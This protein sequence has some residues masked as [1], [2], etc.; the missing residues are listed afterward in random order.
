MRK[1]FTKVNSTIFWV[2]VLTVNLLAQTGCA[3]HAHSSKAGSP[4]VLDHMAVPLSFN[5][6][7]EPILSE[8]CYSCHGP[9]P[10]ARKAGLRID[11]AQFAFV[12]RADG[13]P[14]IVKGDP[15]HS[16]LILRIESKDTK[17]MMPPP[18]A[19]RILKADQVAILRRWVKEGAKY[20]EHWS[21]IPPHRPAV[22][23]TVRTDWPRSPIDK[24]VLAR[25]EREGLAPSPEADSYALIR[26]VT[27]DLIGL[28]PTPEEVDAFVQDRSPGAYE[29][30]V[31]RLLASPGFGEHRAHYWLDLARYGDTHGLHLDNYRSVWPYRDYVIRSF[32]TNKPFDQFACEQLA[33]DL[34]PPKNVDQ[35]VATAF[36][37]AGISSG[38]GGTIPEEL[39]V[40]NQRERTEAF[41]AVFLGLTVGC[42]VCHDHKFDPITQKDFYQLS[43]FWNNLEEFPS[44]KNRDNWPPFI[45]VPKKENQ[46][47]FNATL[48][49][50]ARI[51]EQLN[52]RRKDGRKLLTDWLRQ[53]LHLA[54]PVPS[55]GLKV[56]LRFDEQIGAIA[57]NSAPG[58][59]P[60]KIAATGGAPIWGEETWF[61]PSFRMDTTTRVEL[62]N[63]G[64]VEENQP[65]SIG[66]WLKPYLGTD[67]S[68]VHPFGA[69]VSRNQGTRGWELYFDHDKVSFRLVHSWPHNLIS[70][71]T[72]K[73]VLAR[74]RWNHVLATYDGTC[75]AS[76]IRLYIDGKPQELRVVQDAL[77]GSIHTTSPMELGREFPDSNPL[78]QSI[79]QDLRFYSRAL[80]PDE[81]RRVPYEDY[82][83][84]ITRRPLDDWS[85]D[86]FKTVSD[87]YFSNRD[88]PSRILAAKIPALET[89]LNRL[90]KDGDTCL[91]CQET[92]R[93][94]YANVLDRGVYTQRK[95]RVRPAVPHFLPQP[96]SGAPLDRKTLADWV[97]S[98]INPLTARV[99]VNRMWQELFGDGLVATPENF[100]LMGDR[101]SQPELLD[102]LAV[103]FRESGWNIKRFYKQVVMSATYRQSARVTP[104]ALER[105]PRN[106]LLARGPRFRMDAEMIRDTALAASGLLVSKIGGP[107]V[108]PYQPQ[109]TWESGT[110]D[111]SNTYR[112]VPG[113]GE[114]LYRRSIYTFWKRMVPMPNMEAF[115]AP[116]R[117]GS[118]PRRSLS[119]TPLQALVTMNDPQWLEAARELGERVLTHEATV[120]SR[121]DYLGMLLLGRPLQQNE[122][123]IL[124]QA[125]RRFTS[126]YTAQNEAA[127]NLITV[128][129][130]HPN[131]TISADVLAPWMLV[132]STALNLD[133]T[134]NK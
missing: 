77:T 17:Q 29:K 96:P 97:V 87:F 22:P 134:L 38:E 47:A 83:A 99:T 60:R 36:I 48:T 39:R 125:L 95:V 26:R 124:E 21:F 132:A 111:Y 81:A 107:S 3:P 92:P 8:N 131:S 78:P 114:D 44:D 76:G 112:Y 56:R 80:P 121:L 5:E 28:P 109:G 123:L 64:D 100:G 89:E 15:D 102:W 63:E 71:E 53:G 49:Q 117:D 108:K 119:N 98:P 61:W 79:Y 30:L 18:E 82:V 62:P 16:P 32:N 122:R 86:E 11:R 19:H 51:Q 128:G 10:G 66:T 67:S 54:S 7:I 70:V 91:V 58:A 130:S 72:A 31:D 90:S 129:E 65:F 85:D 120:E 24:F 25:L 127:T 23:A 113:R 9:D 73:P 43:A 84:E 93:L 35:L 45:K 74:S 104:A 2:I 33:G 75:K 55:A 69:I 110:L 126:I 118:C 27:Y 105:D 6:T 46:A 59:M 4:P 133:A 50:R 42:A 116:A 94:A 52:V 37:R 41:G 34:L 88:E 13:G 14:V 115:D 106:R 57:V 103:D 1:H 68:Q 12:P 40:N 20:E 101:P